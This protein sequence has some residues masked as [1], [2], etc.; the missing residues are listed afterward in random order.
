MD[1]AQ[2]VAFAKAAL[3]AWDVPDCTPRLIKNRENA[4]FEVMAPDGER[5]ALRLHRPGYQT[6]AA[7]R[8]EL[9]WSQGLEQA[10]MRLPR[11]LPARDGDLISW[12]APAG[13]MA[14][15]VSWVEG[16]P[17]GDN[18]IAPEWGE[19]MQLHLFSALGTEL[20]QLHRLSD[21]LALP[22]SFE[23]ARLD[24][25]GLLGEQPHW[26][27]F[28]ENPALNPAERDLLQQMRQKLRRIFE[29]YQAQGADFGLIH[30]DALSENVLARGDQV[31]LID[32]D[33]GV[34]GF[35]LY[36][37]GVAMSQVWDRPNSAQLAAALYRGYGLD[38]KLAALIPAFTV[39]RA[40]A[41]CG[42]TIPRYSP[43]DPALIRYA[44]RAVRASE[45][46][47]TGQP[48][49]DGETP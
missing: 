7:I 6:D 4:V 42:W 26:G 49:F 44:N 38:P 11:P 20:A 3:T 22:D 17:L 31:T 19:P 2:A 10:G 48:F 9:L 36:E 24:M 46:F 8:S 15:I 40:L 34:F 43:D 30:A 29:D 14:S 35:R 18:G 37:L 45:R 23:R 12:V 32:F 39:M 1:N 28:W 27:R 5:A 16:V 41:S 25:D 47:M 21:G 33:D 13:R